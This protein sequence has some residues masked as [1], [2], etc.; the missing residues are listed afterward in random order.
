MTK[1]YVTTAIDYVNAAPH[2]GHA[3]E[4]I[5]ADVMA[6]FH[7]IMGEDVF[8]LTGTDE[9]GT[10]LY[11][12][13]RE[14]GLEPQKFCDEMSGSFVELVKVLNISNDY[15]VRTTD[16]RH[17][18]T[19]KKL[20][21]ACK[22]DIYLSKYRGFYCVGCEAYLSERDLKNGK[23]PVHG[24]KPEEIEEENYFFKLS[25]YREDLLSYYDSNPDFIKPKERFN[26]IYSFVESG[27]DDVSVSRSI[28]KLKWGIEVPEDKT[29]VIYVWF[30]ALTNYISAI[31]YRD[32]GKTFEKFWPAD[33]H[34]IGKDITRFHAVMWPAMLMSAGLEL[35]KTI[36]VHGFLTVEG[37]KM[38]KSKGNVLDPFEI[39]EKHGTDPLRYYLVREIP[40]TED[41]DF[42]EKRFKE[43]Y[44]FDL[45]ND[46]GNLLHRNLGIFVKYLNGDVLKNNDFNNSDKRFIEFMKNTVDEYIGEMKK[47]RLREATISA[48]KLVSMANKYVD[49]MAPWSI[50][51]EDSE[52]FKVVSY[53]ICETLRII[54]I[55]I[56]PVMP[57]TADK[58]CD[59]LGIKPDYRIELAKSVGAVKEYKVKKAKPLFP[60]IQE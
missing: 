5:Q 51:K 1:F 54:S 45:A 30:D 7:R 42:S 26:E 59:T 40:T 24:V 20:W 13:A 8:Y 39:A 21:E 58:V 11:R 16:K 36:F 35:P 6:R 15:F 34:V 48:M 43:R 22:K 12:A 57:E 25:R 9:H 47:L 27:L 14:K 46:L 53:L 3:L 18:E 31:G 2:I 37:E 17:E 32:N 23:C 49:E 50:A 10:K 41:G 29:Q 52:R 19:V 44:N 4:K 28:D 60:R 56:R 38:S 33:V 55:I